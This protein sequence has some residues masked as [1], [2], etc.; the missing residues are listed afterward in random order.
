MS[1][2]HEIVSAFIFLE[3]FGY[4]SKRFTF[5]EDVTLE[6][7]IELGTDGRPWNACPSAIDRGLLKT[8]AEQRHQCIVLG[9]RPLLSRV[10]LS[11]QRTTEDLTT[12]LIKASDGFFV[13]SNHVAHVDIASGRHAMPVSVFI[14]TFSIEN[15]Y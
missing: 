15:D 9:N 6:R 13:I 11:T 5:R 1:M 14:N 2:N 3:L 12:P 7:A 8:R 4:Q 10:T